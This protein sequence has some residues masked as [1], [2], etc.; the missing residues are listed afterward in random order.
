MFKKHLSNA[1]GE[2][3]LCVEHMSDVFFGFLTVFQRCMGTERQ[4]VEGTEME[5]RVGIFVRPPKNGGES[6]A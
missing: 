1:L 3:L 6:R 4:E 5:R 2:R